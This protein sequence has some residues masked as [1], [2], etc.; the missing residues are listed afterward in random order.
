MLQHKM[1]NLQIKT[2]KQITNR[3]NMNTKDFK[4]ESETK[5]MR[6]K[7]NQKKELLSLLNYLHLLKQLE[8]ISTILKTN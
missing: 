8:N 5:K 6:S 1:F 3:W 4:Q 7:L 2:K